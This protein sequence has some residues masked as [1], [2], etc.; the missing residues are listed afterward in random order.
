MKRDVRAV[1]TI[2]EV[3]MR[4]TLWARQTNVA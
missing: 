4:W 1:V 3:E 2:R